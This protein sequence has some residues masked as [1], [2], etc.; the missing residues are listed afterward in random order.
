MLTQDNSQ[1]AVKRIQDRFREKSRCTRIQ[2]MLDLVS[3]PYRFKIICVLAE[4]DF[5]VTEIVELVEGKA[6]NISQQLKLLSLSGYLTKE[7]KGKQIYYHLASG[8]IK[9]LF[10]FL[11]T[12]EIT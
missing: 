3:N 1:S 8:F 4:G 6:S 10:D 7:R 11:H 5:P 2:N 12:L 9:E